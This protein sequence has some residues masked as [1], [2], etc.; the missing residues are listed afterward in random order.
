MEFGPYDL[1]MDF[2]LM[3]VL[4]LISQILRANIPLIQKLY[5]PSSLIA[6]FFGLFLGPQFLD[7]IPFS[8]NIGGYPYLLIVFL[9]AGLFIGNNE[10]SSF[11]KVLNE[12]GDT[13]TINTAVEFAQFGA[14]LLIGALLLNRFFPDLHPGFALTMPAGFVGGH[15]Y[16]AAIGG[17]LEKGGWVDAVTMGQTFATIGLL[18]G[19]IG[20]MF[21]IN[22]AVRKGATRFVQNITA[23]PKS[24]QTGLI[25]PAEQDSMGKRT[26]HSMSLDPLTWHL[27][28]VL[29][30]MA[31]GYYGTNLL[32]KLFPN[33]G[34]PMMSVAMIS[35]VVLQTLLKLLKLNQYVDKDVVTRLG[36][37]STDYLVAFGIASIKIS[38]VIQYA[39]PILIMSLV[40]LVFCLFYLFFVCRKLFHNFWFERGIFIYGWSTGVVA[41][42]V[43]LLR[44]VDPE[45]RSRTLEDYGLAYVFIC[46]VEVAIVTLS[47]VM[48][49]Q[50]YALWTGVVYLLIAL[51]LLCVT[52]KIYGV[53]RYKMHEIR[54]GEKE[55]MHK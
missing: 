13:F 37:S 5:L 1:V 41:V 32:D 12:V 31:G 53:S 8:G 43:T 48:V 7:I 4:I 49:L 22:F 27:V 30:A 50:G 21:C 6:G 24:M 18:T 29:I 40:G 17:T 28:I 42:G 38:V 9:F 15:G 25:P 46:L 10:K 39:V 23:L 34:V 54:P 11:K 47:P 36:S 35:G 55:A 14:A 52:A 44:V 2:A 20:G 3:S 26:I 33:I 19:V 45:F 16:A 51:A